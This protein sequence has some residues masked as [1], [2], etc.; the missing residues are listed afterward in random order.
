MKLSLPGASALASL[1]RTKVL[2]ARRQPGAAPLP[3]PD[4]ASH[5][6]LTG[7]PGPE[8]F[9]G[10]LAQAVRLADRESRQLA[11]M[12]VNLDDLKSVNMSAGRG[13]GDAVLR[14]ASKRLRALA[15][16]FMVAR[17]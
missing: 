3:A 16:P 4:T 5:D 11:L 14:E 10:T 13:A 1:L 12:F 9:E 17:L 15:K 7:L 2:G 6:P 8:F